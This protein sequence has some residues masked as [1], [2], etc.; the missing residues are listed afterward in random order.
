MKNVKYIF[1]VDC[2]FWILSIKIQRRNVATR[3]LYETQKYSTVK[4]VKKCVLYF[5]VKE[6]SYINFS[7]SNVTWST[8]HFDIFPRS[9]SIRLAR[10]HRFRCNFA[11]SIF[12]S[13]MIAIFSVYVYARPLSESE[14]D[15]LSLSL[16]TCF[17]SE[18]P[19]SFAV[20]P[21]IITAS[22]PGIIPLFALRDFVCARSPFPCKFGS[23]LG[24]RRNRRAPKCL[25][26]FTPSRWVCLT[27]QLGYPTRPRRFTVP[28]EGGPL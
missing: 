9:R 14:S 6:K 12:I 23:R 25:W 13:P 3:Q 19:Y 2:G 10:S 15:S 4:S 17:S 5:R 20:F 28:G 21:F 26:L 24:T 1:L 22:F 11:A 8:R 18:F 27:N 7:H 16:S